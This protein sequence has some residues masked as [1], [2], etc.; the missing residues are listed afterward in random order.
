MA[1]IL[2]GTSQYA[3][4]SGL[5]S[6]NAVAGCTLMAWVL[7]ELTLDEGM[8][9]D[10]SAGGTVNTRAG[11]ILNRNLSI[12][13]QGR[14]NDAEAIVTGITATGVFSIGLWQHFAATIAYS[15]DLGR[16]F[17]NGAL[18]GTMAMP[19]VGTATAATTSLIAT[20]GRDAGA[21]ADFL[22]GTIEDFRIYN[23]ILGPAEI[24]TIFAQKGSDG[25][26]TG[27]QNRFLFNESGPGVL[28][29]ATGAF[30]DLGP[31]KRNF[32]PVASPA[33]G[34][35]VIRARSRPLMSRL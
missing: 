5:T 2:N 25:I 3:T 8:V 19:F 17:V 30:V 1:L 7:P 33:Y 27:L 24:L 12:T 14:A 15:V 9:V 31:N 18:V 22:D 6:I 10:I 34:T 35:G 16:A 21:A 4:I 26:L 20:I 13:V 23:R 32:T 11:L 29:T 28:A